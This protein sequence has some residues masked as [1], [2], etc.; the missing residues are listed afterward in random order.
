M[1]R[2]RDVKGRSA[3]TSGEV[4]SSW[5][6]AKSVAANVKTE[7]NAHSQYQIKRR[8]LV[9]MSERVS[10]GE[11]MVT[12]KLELEEVAWLES[13]CPRGYKLYALPY[14]DGLNCETR[15]IVSNTSLHELGVRD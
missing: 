4:I 7:R 12:L 9:I 10:A 8:L 3:Q 14:L 1:E 11:T 5:R 2:V 6:T 15:G 13:S